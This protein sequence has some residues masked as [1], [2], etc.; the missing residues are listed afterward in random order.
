[1]SFVMR[2]RRFSVRG[3]NSVEGLSSSATPVKWRENS[4]QGDVA[5]PA[6]RIVDRDALA[7]HPGEDDEVIE[8]PVQYARQLQ[9]REMLEV[10]PERAGHQVELAREAHEVGQRRASQRDR[11]TRAQGGEVDLVAVMACNHCEGR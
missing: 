10:Q 11:V 9:L 6:C 7:A 8:V 4:G 3:W 2:T 1:M 5:L